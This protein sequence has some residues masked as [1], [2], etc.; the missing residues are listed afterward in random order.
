MIPDDA[1]TVFLP[2]AITAIVFGLPIGAFV[3]FRVLAH[4]ERMAMIR[5]GMPVGSSVRGRAMPGQ[6]FEAAYATEPPQLTLNKG[7][8]LALIGFAVTL[9]LGFATLHSSDGGISWHPGP[10]LL[11][12]LVPMFIG[13]AQIFIAV[14]GG[15][16]VATAVNAPAPPSAPFAPIPQP[17]V[18]PSTPGP[19]EFYPPATSS[20]R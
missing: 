12:G 10:W 11:L 15:A 9:G 16:G 18:P 4:R 17:P 7:I 13:I 3:L 2:I 8:R 5:A 1:L 6:P 19:Q 14:L 20:E